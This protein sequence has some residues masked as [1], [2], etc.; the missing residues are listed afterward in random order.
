MRRRRFR[1]HEIRWQK[2]G[3]VHVHS[4]D[5]CFIACVEKDWLAQD[6]IV[7]LSIGGSLEAWQSEQAS[8]REEVPS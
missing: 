8:R 4:P 1:N 5:G 2:D 3:H 7:S 6:L